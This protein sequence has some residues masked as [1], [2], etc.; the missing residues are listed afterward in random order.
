MS[1]SGSELLSEMQYALGEAINELCRY[2]VHEYPDV[3]HSA[4]PQDGEA[5]YYPRRRPEDSQIDINCPLKNHFNFLRTVDNE[6]YPAWFEYNGRR[7]I[8]QI[9]SQGDLSLN[10]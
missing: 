5:T 8:L 6:K 3:I 4:I 10:N 7:Y 2:F 1:F 9:I